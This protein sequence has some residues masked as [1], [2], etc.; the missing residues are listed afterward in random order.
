[1][2]TLAFDEPTEYDRTGFGATAGVNLDDGRFRVEAG[3]DRFDKEYQ[4]LRALT[5]DR[6][7]ENEAFSFGVYR[8]VMTR[9]EIL[10]EG[11]RT[12]IDY[13]QRPA[14]GISLSNVENRVVAGVAWEA[15]AKTRGALKVGGTSKDFDDFRRNDRSNVSWEV[16]VTWQPRTY[17]RINVNGFRGPRE[18]D[19]QGDSIDV[20]RLAVRWDH[21]F[22]DRTHGRARVGYVREEYEGGDRD[23]DLWRFEIGVEHDLRRWLSA[24]VSYRFST[25]DSSQAAAD[26]DRNII[27]LRIQA[28]L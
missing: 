25:R 8:Q 22:S 17:S 21:D 1:M 19:G 6:D 5:A 13:D 28:G 14:S 18:T 9:T 20:R 16:D 27:A 26:F 23:D 11:K 3:Y 12:D 2:T 4:N 24:D 15:T 10:L 7:R